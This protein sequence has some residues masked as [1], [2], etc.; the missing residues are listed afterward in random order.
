MYPTAVTSR[1]VTAEG[2]AVVAAEM[3]ASDVTTA[4]VSAATAKVSASATK[5]ASPTAAVAAS[6]AVTA[7][8]LCLAE[9]GHHE[10]RRPGQEQRAGERERFLKHDCA[11][12]C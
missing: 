7:P 8:A 4:E 5:V 11:S 1:V 6:T 10:N 9:T 2:A 12:L 3:G